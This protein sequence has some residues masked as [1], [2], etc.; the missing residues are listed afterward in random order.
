LAIF[1]EFDKEVYIEGVN[2]CNF[3]GETQDG[4]GTLTLS[5]ESMKNFSQKLKTLI[6]KSNEKVF[7]ILLVWLKRKSF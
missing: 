7:T 6:C 1:G 2:N 5:I 4:G 3:S